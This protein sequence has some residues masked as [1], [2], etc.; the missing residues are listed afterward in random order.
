MKN[1]QCTKQLQLRPKAS[2]T[3]SNRV[4]TLILV[5]GALLNVPL[6][7]TPCV[8]LGSLN[9]RRWPRS[10]RFRRSTLCVL[11][12]WTCKCS[13]QALGIVRL[14]VV[15]EVNVGVV[16]RGWNRETAWQAA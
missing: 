12:V 13:W 8:V 11:E 5:V 16:W 14:R 15:V 2:P 3:I 7:P 6:L 10:F 1:F 4:G 9:H